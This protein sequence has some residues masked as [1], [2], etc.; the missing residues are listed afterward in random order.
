MAASQLRST[1]GAPPGA[2][3]AALFRAL[4][5]T[6]AHLIVLVAPDGTL[7]YAGPSVE[8]TLGYTDADVRGA[9]GLA[10]LH[11]DDRAR[12]VE[13]FTR[14]VA[15]SG[16]A[17]PCEVRVRHADGR[18]VR[19]DVVADNRLA[20]ADLQGIVLTATPDVLPASAANGTDAVITSNLA[21]RVTSVSPS[22][23]A[24]FGFTPEELVG[25]PVSE[26]FPG[27]LEEARGIMRRLT[28]EGRIRDY[29]STFPGSGG[30]VIPISASIALLRDN[31]GA[32]T[33]AIG[34]LKDVTE[35]KRLAAIAHD[36]NNLLTVIDGRCELLLTR[37]EP[38]SEVEGDVMIIRESAHRASALA[39]ELLLATRDDAPAEPAA[40]AVRAPARGTETLLLVE[41]EDEVRT[42][43]RAILEQNGYRIFEAATPDEALLLAEHHGDGIDLMVTDLV[44]PVMSGRELADRVV[45]RHP[46]LRVLFMSG[47]AD[48]ALAPQD[49]LG[50]DRAFVAKPFSPAGL[51]S[52]VREVIDGRRSS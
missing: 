26:L 29:A 35:R 8:R 46:R 24:M 25:W 32:V 28:T 22:V 9:W 45:A 15:R 30:R 41:D 19:L 52:K 4:L 6:S 7:R 17:E 23:E 31:S 13:A 21:G 47:H 20:D 38:I 18:W 43:A 27:G 36:F 16:R 12:A 33:G 51:A 49:V 3:A 42:L 10:L 48:T 44:M 50:P 5:P 11:P 14:T 40:P 34:V 39:R 1:H 37:D 2:L